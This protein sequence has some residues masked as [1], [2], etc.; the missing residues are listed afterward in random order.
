MFSTANILY[1]LSQIGMFLVAFCAPFL[2]LIHSITFLV[3]V[4]LITAIILQ[5]KTKEGFLNKV[6]VVQSKK[7]RKS[8]I[9][10]FLYIIFIVSVYV[11][12]DTIFPGSGVSEWVMKITFFSLAAVE[13]SSIAANMNHITGKSVFTKTLNKI[14]EKLTKQFD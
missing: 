10:L 11:L 9:K 6:K 4:D 13:V 3:F 12:I 14:V 1:Y 8:A 5:T 2:M 7:L